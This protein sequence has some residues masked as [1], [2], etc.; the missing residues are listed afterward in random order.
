VPLML[1]LAE[2]RWP[3][4]VLGVAAVLGA[5]AALVVDDIIWGRA[6]ALTT[7]PDVLQSE[8]DALQ[9]SL[10]LGERR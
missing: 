3:D 5:A 10:K 9:Q 4:L 6:V 2:S 8:R 1:G 7:R